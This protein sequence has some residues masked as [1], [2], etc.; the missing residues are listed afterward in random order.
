VL[1]QPPSTAQAVVGTPI[2]ALVAL[3]DTAQA[4]IPTALPGLDP[5]MASEVIQAYESYWRVRGQALLDLDA[6]HLNEVMAGDHLEGVTKRIDELRNEGRAIKTDVQHQY[7]LIS[8]KNNTAQIVDDYISNSIYVD[9]ITQQPLSD[10]VADE[11]RVLYQLNKMDGTWKVV[12]SVG[13]E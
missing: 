5:A 1:A 6:T 9:P 11:L 13:A 10:P 4:V 12:D 3:T 2:T 7:Q 8:L